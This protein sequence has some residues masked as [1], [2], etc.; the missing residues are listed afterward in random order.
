MSHWLVLT[1]AYLQ[2]DRIQ[3]EVELEESAGLSVDIHGVVEY[4]RY[5]NTAHRRFHR[6]GAEL[7]AAERS[8]AGHFSRYNSIVVRWDWESSGRQSGACI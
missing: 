1:V 3:P 5:R 4:V 2:H 6:C 8:N 7:N